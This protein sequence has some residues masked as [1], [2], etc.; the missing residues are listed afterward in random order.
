[1]YYTPMQEAST[2]VILT[3]MLKKLTAFRYKLELLTPDVSK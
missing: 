1:M 2:G 3:L